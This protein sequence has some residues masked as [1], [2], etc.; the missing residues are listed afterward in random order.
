[1]PVDETNKR[2]TGV[3]VDDKMPLFSAK[4]KYVK[5]Y[6]LKSILAD[7]SKFCSEHK[8]NKT[9]V[10]FF[11][12]RQHLEDVNDNRAPSIDSLWA[13]NID[14]LSPSQCLALRVD[15]LQS[16][17]N[18]RAQYYFLK[19]KGC[20]IFCSPHQLDMVE[21]EFLPQSVRFTVESEFFGHGDLYHTPAKPVHSTEHLKPSTGFEP[22]DLTEC[23]LL[24]E[25]PTPN[26]KGVR[27]NYPEAIA[28]TL[29]ELDPL[30]QEGLSR[31][32]LDPNDPNILLKTY[33]KDGADGMGDVSV[34]WE[35]SQCALPDKAFRFAFAVIKVTTIMPNGSELII[36][37][38]EKPNSIRTNRPLLEAIA[39]ENHKSSC[40]FCMYPI[41]QERNFLKGKI[42]R[43]N[44]RKEFWRRHE[45]KFFN[46]MID[47]KFDRAESGLA[48]SGSRFLCTLCTATREEAKS[49]LGT[50]KITRTYTDTQRIAEYIQCNPDKLSSN[51]LDKVSLG[52]KS[53]PIIFAD[54]IEKGI[55]AT[56]SDINMSSFFKKII[57]REIAGVSFW[58]L[59]Q[60]IKP[61]V[62]AAEIKFDNVMRAATG[63]NPA[64]MMPGNYARTLFDEKNEHVAVS[65][66]SD[67]SRRQLVL[68]ILRKF[69]TL[70]KI[71]RSRSPREEYPDDL[72]N[73]KENAVSMGRF[74]LEHFSYIEW[75]NYLHKVIEHVQEFI[76]DERGPGSVGSLSGEG[77]EGGNKVFRY[78]RKQLSRKGDVIG[79]L[80]DVLQLHWLY[81]SKALIMLSNTTH[82]QN[83]CSLCY[84]LGH[85]RPSCPN[86]VEASDN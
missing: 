74:L 40:I 31:N 52:V 13:G 35:K 70:R 73:Y 34:Y 80:R 8:E 1:M 29:E 7:V 14:N 64:L 77:N 58:E 30:I 41:E 76:E 69:R 32:N 53:A 82:K 45:I 71:Y 21:K 2:Q 78:F 3:F 24:P 84:S 81:S 18:Y 38:E 15:T 49:M 55:D 46:S 85:K 86:N 60:D 4:R 43:V 47:E 19:E 28:K 57:L 65:L 75:P 44:V 61:L 72:K 48:G 50:F 12:L 22:I 62:C 33:I 66:I 27:Y 10:L 42:I 25:F 5:Q 51:E 59:K 37:E 56:H 23:L 63:I 17:G 54:A 16:K 11:M 26:L 83:R 67:S 36:F 79:G 6:R 9:D 39:D 68:E 20:H